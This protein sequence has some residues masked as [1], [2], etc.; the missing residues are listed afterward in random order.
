[1]VFQKLYYDNGP[2]GLLGNHQKPLFIN[3][4]RDDNEKEDDEG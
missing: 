2:Q 4:E 1:M 3:P